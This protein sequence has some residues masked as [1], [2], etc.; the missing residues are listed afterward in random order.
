MAK[1]LDCVSPWENTEE[2]VHMQMPQ[3]SCQLQLQIQH[4]TP[5]L[6][7]AGDPEPP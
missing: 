2:P 7:P 1:G 5:Q 3:W 6:R 4:C